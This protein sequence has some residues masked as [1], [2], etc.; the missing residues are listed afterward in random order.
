MDV[1]WSAQ[2]KSLPHDPGHY[3][4]LTLMALLY[5]QESIQA[6]LS[7]LHD[8]YRTLAIE[9]DVEDYDDDDDA[10]VAHWEREIAAG[11]SPDL[12]LKESPSADRIR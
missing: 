7:E 1:A 10:L 4:H 12:D 6:G 8:Y 9:D 11:R 3:D 2:F 5:H